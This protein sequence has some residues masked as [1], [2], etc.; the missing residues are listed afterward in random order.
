VYEDGGDLLVVHGTSKKRISSRGNPLERLREL[1]EAYRPVT[2]PGLP[3]F[4]GGAVGYLSYDMV[5]TFE[6]LATRKKDP[7]NLPDFAFLLTDTMLIFDNVAQKIKVVATA[8]VT[9]K[10]ERG[11]KTAYRSPNASTS[12]PPTSVLYG[13]HEQSGF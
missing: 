13:E 3:P 1:M 11:I 9:A 8:H 12:P 7:L 4:V 5:R 10:G 2:V 6:D